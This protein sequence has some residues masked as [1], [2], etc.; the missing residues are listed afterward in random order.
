M[1]DL[2]NLK[3]GRAIFIVTHDEAMAHALLEEIIQRIGGGM[4]TAAI[5]PTRLIGSIPGSR[6]PAEGVFIKD[7]V[8]LMVMPRR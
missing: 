2:E 4:I 5:A 7:G 6:K 8:T 3:A 1:D